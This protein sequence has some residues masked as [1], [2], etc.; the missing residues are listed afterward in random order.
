MEGAVQD[1]GGGAGDR[2]HIA[3]FRTSSTRTHTPGGRLVAITA[4]S[5]TRCRRSFGFRVAFAV[6]TRSG[7]YLYVG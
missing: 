6:R 2:T 1:R 5:L 7:L 3:S 4:S